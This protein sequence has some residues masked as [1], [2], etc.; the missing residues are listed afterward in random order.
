AMTAE[1]FG[2]V[3]L[4]LARHTNTGESWDSV[5]E[6]PTSVF[7]FAEYGRRFDMEENFLDHNSNGFQ[8]ESS[9]VR[10]A[11]ALTRLCLGLA[12]AML[13]LV[14]QGTQVVAQQK[15]RWVAPHYLRGNLYLR[16]GGEWGKTALARG[17]ELC[18][19]LHLSGMPDPEPCR[20]S[21]STPVPAPPVT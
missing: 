7:T 4:A 13:Y 10:D 5:S 1:Q 6:E 15:R 16:V 21:A 12:V 18:T 2:P 11:A 8:L 19:T 17:W 9:L 14:A 20:A 3:P